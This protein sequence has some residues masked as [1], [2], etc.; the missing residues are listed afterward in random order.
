MDHP[1]TYCKEPARTSVPLE[2]IH[3]LPAE[4]GGRGGGCSGS[5]A[6]A[7]GK[8]AKQQCYG[9]GGQGPIQNKGGEF[10]A[11]PRVA[12]IRNALI[13]TES[14]RNHSYLI[15]FTEIAHY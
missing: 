15:P 9:R 14:K 11:T 1:L 4:A 13:N 2:F 5:I 10:S 6:G 12:G 8:N 3:F 7:G